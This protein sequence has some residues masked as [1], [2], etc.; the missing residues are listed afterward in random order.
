MVE[1]CIEALYSIF[2]TNENKIELI[3]RAKMIRKIKLIFLF[4]FSKFKF[5]WSKVNHV[6]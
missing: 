2:S 3:F 5:K 1:I 4:K 6:G